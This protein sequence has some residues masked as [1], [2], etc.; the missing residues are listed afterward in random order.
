VK[1]LVEPKSEEGELESRRKSTARAPVSTRSA[2]LDAAKETFARM[3]FE[4]ATFAEIAEKAG[5][6]ASQ[7]NYHFCDKAQLYR[8]SLEAAVGEGRLEHL[9]GLLK[10]PSNL[11][12]FRLRL[13]L[14]AGELLERYVDDEISM[15]LLTLEISRGLPRGRDL[16]EAKASQTLTSLLDFMREARQRGLLHESVDPRLA[17]VN[18]LSTL[19]FLGSERELLKKSLGLSIENERERTAIIQTMVENLI[20][21]F[22]GNAFGGKNEAPS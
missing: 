3:G 8:A 17:V 22:K 12:E 1:K 7:I 4:G 9:L 15:R 18:I 19:H 11:T 5:M 2:L 14:V 6:T 10:S 21:G 20:A 16:I 13:E